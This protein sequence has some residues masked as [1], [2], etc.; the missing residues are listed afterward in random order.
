MPINSGYTFNTF[1]I[2]INMNH[3]PLLIYLCVN[4]VLVD[5]ITLPMYRIVVSSSPIKDC[6]REPCNC[7][8]YLEKINGCPVCHSHRAMLDLH[9][10]VASSSTQQTEIFWVDIQTQAVSDSRTHCSSCCTI[11]VSYFHVKQCPSVGRV[12]DAHYWGWQ[13]G[14]HLFLRKED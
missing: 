3:M 13:L 5:N 7:C 8:K 12:V 9:A 6:Q 4:P 10:A 14:C 2:L 11:Q 1:W